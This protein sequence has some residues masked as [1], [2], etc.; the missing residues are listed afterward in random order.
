MN[1][2]LLYFVFFFE[3]MTFMDYYERQY[4]IKIRFKN[5]PMVVN[6]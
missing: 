4:G 1:F 6:R 3:T 5:Q 2:F